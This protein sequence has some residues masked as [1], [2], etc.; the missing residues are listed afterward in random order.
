MDISK[1]DFSNLLEELTNIGISLSAEKNHDRLLELILQKAMELTCAD[2]GTLYT[3]T[4][5]NRLEFEIMITNSLGIRKGGTSGEQIEFYPISLYD[6]DDNPN[7]HMV[8]SWAVLSGQTANIED[9]YT[10]TRFDFSGT[11]EFDKK[12]GYRSKSFLTVPLTNHEN[13]NIGVLQLLNALDPET[14]EVGTFSELDQHVVESLA[15]Q[16]A[17]T[18]T[19]RSLIDAQRNLFDAMIQLIASAIDEK[20]AYTGGHCR[21]VPELTSMLAEAACRIDYGP[22]K[23]FDL[24]EKEKYALDVAGWLHDCGK[25]TTPE[26][27]VDKGTKLETIFDRIEIVNTRFEVLKRDA[28]IKVLCRRLEQHGISHDVGADPGFQQETLALVNDNEFI[29]KMNIGGEFTSDEDRERV[30][31][32]ANR[33][34][35]APDGTLSGLLTRNEVDN[36]IIGRGTLTVREREIINNHISV[37]ID[38]LESLPYPKHLRNVPEYAGGHHEKMDG[39]G[40]PRGLHREQMSIPARMMGIADI[41]EALTAGDRPYKK[42]MPLSRA[43]HI[44]GNMKLENHIDPD[45]FDLF[46]HEKIYLKYAEKY[47]SSDQIDEFDITGI[48]GYA[49]VN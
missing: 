16:A 37:T 33:K 15:S 7:V 39:T 10:N 36:L 41:F 34:W 20:S 28:E 12:T 22:L 35:T 11:R 21:R 48:P 18:I 47:L 49:P 42:A 9:A 45:L 38:M 23:D 26:Y 14:G 6:R 4:E 13:E 1:V 27:V 24:D 3:R 19:N 44:L 25:I 30:T 46:I 32:I 43:L 5:D 31:R 2:G 40:Y 29:R 8:A 17:V